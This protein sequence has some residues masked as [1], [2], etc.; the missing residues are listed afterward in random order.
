MVTAVCE[1]VS[2]LDENTSMIISK[3]GEIPDLI[4]RSFQLG[5]SSVQAAVIYVESLA[6]DSVINKEAIRD[7]ELFPLYMFA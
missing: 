3:L 4:H 6:D 5:D 1:L 2:S 7:P